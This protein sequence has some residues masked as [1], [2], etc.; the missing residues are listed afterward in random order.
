[1]KNKIRLDESTQNT[2]YVKFTTYTNGHLDIHNVVEDNNGSLT[3]V[4]IHL[5]NGQVLKFYEYLKNN[6][7]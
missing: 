2:S 7:K 5:D 1:M 3:E 6:L 4:S